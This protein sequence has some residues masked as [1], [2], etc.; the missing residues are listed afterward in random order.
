MKFLTKSKSF[1]LNIPILLLTLVTNLTSGLAFAQVKTFDEIVNAGKYNLELREFEMA[2][3]IFQEGFVLADSIEDNKWQANL[4]FYMGLTRQ[5]QAEDSN[6]KIKR[7]E[8]FE[9]A[10]SEYKRLLQLQPNSGVAK[11]NLAQIYSQLGE[12]DKAEQLYKEAIELEDQKEPFYVM[13]FAEFLSTTGN[14]ERAIDYYNIVLTKQP[15]NVH[16]YQKL[17]DIYSATDSSKLLPFFWE[18]LNNG[19]VIRTQKSALESLNKIKWFEREKEELLTIIVVCLSK[20][21]YDPRI[22]LDSDV[23]LVLE[24]SETDQSIGDGIKELFD[25]HFISDLSNSNFNWWRHKIKPYYEAPRGVWPGEGFMMLMRSIG[26]WYRYN[27]KYKES[28]MIYLLSAEF[29]YEPDSESL[30]RL[31]DLYLTIDDMN[32]LE[33]LVN[34]YIPRLFDIK[35]IAYEKGDVKKIYYLHRALGVIYANLKQW[36]N[37]SI[38][39]SAIFQLEHAIKTI[40]IINSSA[41]KEEDK[42]NLEPRLVSLLADGYNHNGDSVKAFS[43]RIEAAQEYIQ[44]NDMTSAKLVLDPI[45]ENGMPNRIDPNDKR[46]YLELID[47]INE[48]N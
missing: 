14:Q 37:E 24:K 6:E 33:I 21:Y 40:R 4:L 27:G 19:Y 48:N 47:I 2:F 34:K 11:N 3:Q 45:Q 38:V 8:Y 29:S 17:I 22:F 9:L 16:A 5:Q 20:Q 42:I 1:Q 30:L 43:V 46:L 10:I 32:K 28:E 26:D 18:D 36:G 31:T 7:K 12:K 13:N 25:L 23:Y 15:E 44:N 41:E 35:R 39:T